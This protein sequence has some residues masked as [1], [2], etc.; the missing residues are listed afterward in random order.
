MHDK[1][2][3][4]RYVDMP[5]PI[6]D[7][8]A[9]TG[10]DNRPASCSLRYTPT[11][12]IDGRGFRGDTP[13]TLFPATPTTK[14]TPCG[15][16]LSCHGFA[17]PLRAVAALSAAHLRATHSPDDMRFDIG[18]DTR[19]SRHKDMAAFASRFPSRLGIA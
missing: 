16:G 19:T 5:I 15:R 8:K 12:S 9:H 18:N 3:I 11:P 14:S 17:H 4:Q 6:A 2:S 10:A 13:M 1:R 7:I